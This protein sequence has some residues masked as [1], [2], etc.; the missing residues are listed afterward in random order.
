MR[1]RIRLSLG[2]AR[3]IPPLLC[4]EGRSLEVRGADSGA[5]G[6]L[7]FPEVLPDLLCS[8]AVVGPLRGSSN[9]LGAL[10][11]FHTLNW[12]RVGSVQ[13]QNPLLALGPELCRGP[14]IQKPSEAG[15]GHYGR[16]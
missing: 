12:L 11:T 13:T 1:Q 2:G 9:E 3:G 15:S 8:H 4:A 5:E 7:G 16:S 6:G 10:M 14:S